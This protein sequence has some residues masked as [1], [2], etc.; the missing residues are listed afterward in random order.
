MSEYREIWNAED[1]TEAHIEEAISL[2][3]GEYGG[4]VVPW[5]EV[6]DRIEASDEDWGSFS[7]SPAI[8]HLKAEVNRAIRLAS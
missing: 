7:D 2:R 1:V 8:R 3:S 4:E 5:D 6:I